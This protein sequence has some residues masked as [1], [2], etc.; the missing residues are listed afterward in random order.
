MKKE[1][2]AYTQQVADGRI[3]I[4]VVG[5]SF[6]KYIL[7]CLQE[8]P[9]NHLFRLAAVCDLRQELAN[10]VGGKWGAKI[11]YSLDDLLNDPEIKIIGLFTGP[12]GRA[13]LIRQIIRSGKDVLTTKP[14]ELCH[15]EAQSI[16]SEA[17]ALGRVIHLN[18]P[19]PELTDELSQILSWRDEKDLGRLVAARADV[20]VSYFE[21]SDGSWMDDPLSCPGGPMMRLGIYLINDLVTLAGTPEEILLR[22]SRVRTGRPTPDNALL[23][24]TFA[25]GCLGSIYASFCVEDGDHYSNGMSLQ[26]ERGSI[27][28]NIGVARN[29]TGFD[30]SLV[31]L[32]RR[33]PEGYRIVEDRAFGECSGIYQWQALHEA[34]QQEKSISREYAQ[35]ILAGVKVIEAMRLSADDSLGLS[36]ISLRPEPQAALA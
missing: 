24:M 3:P 30:K 8:D 20:W 5:L 11:F 34:V 16:L 19:S 1:S 4:A 21:E 18:S 31:S 29:Q 13:D 15:A 23:T 32:V 10:E 2:T 7:K 9:A 35:N 25:D 27:Y 17:R 33:G 36:G 22:T 14:F 6:G 26:F 28:R 12:S